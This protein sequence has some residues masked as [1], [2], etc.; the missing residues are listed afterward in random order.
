MNTQEVAVLQVALEGVPLPATRAELVEYLRSQE[1]S[2]VPALER[3]PD[4]KYERI[5]AV[6]EELLWPNGAVPAETPLP[7]PESGLPPGGDAYVST[8]GD[9][10]A[11]RHDAPP[12]NPPQ[13]AIDQATALRNAQQEIQEKD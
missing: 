3:L 4:R 13:R 2:L 5:D 10:G 8:N 12:D 6:A 7:R 1:P 9:A 11:V